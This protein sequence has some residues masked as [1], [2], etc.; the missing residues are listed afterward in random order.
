MF[1]RSLSRLSRRRQRLSAYRRATDMYVLGVNWQHCGIGFLY[2][3]SQ[4]AH[5]CVW[6]ALGVQD[7]LGIQTK[8]RHESTRRLTFLN[9]N[10][11][12][13]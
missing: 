9:I 12:G 10:V 11:V 8:K 2:H 7:R 4:S 1:T 13:L 3:I 6:A 5:S